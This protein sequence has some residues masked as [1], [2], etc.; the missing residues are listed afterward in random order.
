MRA[1]DRRSWL[2]KSF[3]ASAGLGL[4]L[5]AMAGEDYLPRNVHAP[6][7]I[8]NLG[9]NE[10]PYG[11]SPL[12]RQA[13]LDKM[14]MSNRYPMNVK[15]VATFKKALAESLGV[16]EKNILMTAGSGEGLNLLARSY[17][18]GDL[19]TA[20]PTFP[21]L[22]N[23]S[24]K[25][26]ITVKEIA[27]TPDKV[28]DLPAIENAVNTQTSLVYICN[29]AN[30]TGTV[31]DPEKLSRFCIA[32]AR[33]AT[34]VID[35]AYI[36]LVDPPNNI[37]MKS[38]VHDNPRIVVIGTFSKI[39]AMAGLRVGYIVGHPTTIQ[40]LEGSY[41]QQ[42]SSCISVLSSL[43]AAASLSDKAYL[44]DCKK[45]NAAVRKHTMEHLQQMGYQTIPSHTNFLFFATPGYIGDF[46]RDMLEKHNIILRSSTYT[47]GK[48]ARVSIG[49]QQEM[50]VFLDKIKLMR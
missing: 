50:E 2:K 4:S 19:V 30:P 45:K 39:H 41:F 48:W 5:R 8:I 20:T 44:A 3:L 15:E 32:V 26:G 17:S 16:G 22:P 11:I 42:A 9:F 49:T 28:H 33:Q 24:K 1:I 36:D 25:L 12:A 35:E 27:L 10:N 6:A 21:I 14:G 34:V 29:P 47:D 18:S 38:L 43:A 40:Q 7:D 37:S 31:I 46:A 13:I 23:T